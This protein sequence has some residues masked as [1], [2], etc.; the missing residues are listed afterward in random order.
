[1]M[2]NKYQHIILLAFAGIA[3]LL[4]SCSDFD[5]Y[6]FEYRTEE[7]AINPGDSTENSVVKQLFYACYIDLPLLHTRFSSSYLDAATDDGVPTQTV[8]GSSDLNNYRNGLLTPGNIANL[9]G[10]A[11]KRNYR[12]IRRVNLFLDKLSVFP[13]STQV[14]EA[15]MKQMKSEA[16]LLRAYYYFELMKRWGGVPL[17]GDAVLNAEDDINIPKSSI[18]ELADYIISEISPDSNNSCYADLHDAQSTASYDPTEIGHVNKGVALAL[19]SRLKLYLASPLYNPDNDADKWEEAA[20]AAKKLIDLGVYDLYQGTQS[21]MFKL[22]AMSNDDFPNKEMIMIKQMGSNSA[23]EVTNSPVGYSYGTGTGTLRNVV[24]LGRTS[25][26]QNLVD[27]FLTIDGK[28]IYKNYNSQEGYDPASGYDEQ[29]PY[30]DRDPRL[31]RT[32]FLNG[33]SWL[34]QPVETFDGG[35]NRGA[36]QGIT[37]T[38]TGYYLKKFL[39]N[40][41]FTETYNNYNHHYQIFRYAEIL[42]NYAEAMN[43]SEPGNDTEI[44]YG[45]I[46]LRKRAGINAGADGRYGLPASYSQD[47]MRRIIR[48]ERRIEMA[49]EDQRFWD[50]RRWKICAVGD[51][52][53]VMTQ[54]VRG[55][56]IKKQGDGTFTYSYED[57]TPSV[58]EK[59]MYWYPIPR[60]ELY[61]NNQLIQNDDWNY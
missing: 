40:N 7:W 3:L 52:D 15:R 20:S 11:W 42:L 54:P 25:P 36:I 17:V 8:A 26:S 33:S 61:G 29:V 55:V 59:R 41:E 32:V 28:S 22:F 35:V 56:R 6:P 21:T 27:A 48:N 60:A 30:K 34:K 12:G 10:D 39:G 37:Y 49:F 51:G 14:P 4:S 38:R 18:Q 5:P 44:I 58:F 43:E 46:Q 53:A 47:L 13:P 31:A 9:D 57:V 50:I 23:I 16:R 2:R 19:L 24:S 1:M 45:L